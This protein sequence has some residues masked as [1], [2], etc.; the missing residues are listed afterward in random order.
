MSPNPLNSSNSSALP[1]EQDVKR[2]TR[3]IY[4]AREYVYTAWFPDATYPAFR[5]RVRPALSEIAATLP[6][7]VG[8]AVS[9]EA[10]NL[11][12]RAA[13]QEIQTLKPWT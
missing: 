1:S 8:R 9:L 11:R 3:A 2:W 7:L 6:D 13:L 4:N 5:D 12:L 10:E